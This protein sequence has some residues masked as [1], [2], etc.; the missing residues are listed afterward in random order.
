MPE[1]RPLHCRNEGELLAEIRQIEA[2]LKELDDGDC[3][4]EKALVRSYEYAIQQY[5]ARLMEMRVA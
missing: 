4:Y 1:H 2:R 5:R 3:A